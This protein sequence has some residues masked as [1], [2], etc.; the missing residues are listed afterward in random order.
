MDLSRLIYKEARAI[1]AFNYRREQ[2]R[3]GSNESTGPLESRWFR[4]SQTAKAGDKQEVRERLPQTEIHRETDH[5]SAHQMSVSVRSHALRRG[6]GHESLDHRGRR[7]L[8]FIDRH[9][10]RVRTGESRRVTFPGGSRDCPRR[11]SFD[12]A[13]R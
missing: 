6:A 10:R 13:D 12:A 5:T 9:L 7:Q 2:E 3:H 8:R 1:S 4:A 11:G